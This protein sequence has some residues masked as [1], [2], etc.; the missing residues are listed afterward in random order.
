M[1]GTHK[2]I[3][4]SRLLQSLA[5]VCRAH[6]TAEK[7]LL[8]PSYQIGREILAAL[9]G[10]TG[11]WLNLRLETPFSLALDIAAPRMAAE[12]RT[13]VAS[14]LH[15]AILRRLYATLDKRFFPPDPTPGILAAIGQALEEIR[16]AE[17]PP[18]D[19]RILRTTDPAK[20]ADLEALLMRYEQ[21][22]D[23]A[24]AV[25]PP[26]VYR[27]ARDANASR[28]W[29][30][31]IPE[32]LRLP[33]MISDLLFDRRLGE[34]LVLEEDPG[35]GVDAPPGLAGHRSQRSDAPVSPLSFLFAPE[36][37]P[38]PPPAIEI[39]AAVGERNECREVLR[40]ILARSSRLDQV[41]IILADY[42][43]YAP[44]LDDLCG[45]L[46]S[47]PVTFAGGL[48]AA[49]S[50]PA[51]AVAA[52]ARWFREGFPELTLR[53]LL[54]SGDLR[55]PEGTTGRRAAHMLRAAQVG[56]GADR[57]A[58]CLNGY[59]AEILDE[60]HD[61]EDPTDAERLTLRLAGAKAARDWIL[62]LLGLVPQ[63]KAPLGD[64]LAAA[65]AFLEGYVAIRSPIDAAT[66]AQ[67]VVRLAAPPVEDSAPIAPA[68]AAEYILNA[69]E[70]IAVEASGS[71]PGHLHVSSIRNGGYTG[72]PVTY[73]LGLDDGRFPGTVFQDPILSDLERERLGVAMAV[74]R[75][76]VRSLEA[77]YAFGACLARLR[78]EIILSHAAFDLADGRRRFPSPALLQAHR[79]RTGDPRA[80]YEDLIR[81]V[82]P[83]IGFVGAS[84]P[85]DAGDWWLT[86]LQAEGRLQEARASVLA[87]APD[88]ARGAQADA[89]RSSAIATPHDGRLRPD[90]ARDPRINRA[91]VFSASRLEC[92]PSCPHKYFLKYVLRVEPPD[93]VT[94]E[95]G[96]WLDPMARGS[97]LHE[98]YRR[99]LDTFAKRNEHP[100]P[101]TH[102][103]E[104]WRIL[105][106]CIQEVRRR[107]PPPSEAVFQFEVE[108]LRR[109]VRVFLE[110]EATERATNRPSYFEVGFGMEGAE[111]IGTTTPV[112]IRLPGG[113][114][115]LRGKIDRIDR[116]SRAH[117]WEV[118]DYKTG[119]SKTYLRTQY[120]NG[121]TQLQHALY[122][123]V[124]ETLLRQSVD[125]KATV[126]GSGYLFPTERGGGA[127][128]RRD[129]A[130]AD[131]ALAVVAQICDGIRD[132]IFL[133]ADAWCDY[134]DYAPVCGSRGAA[135]W[136]A[137]EG[138]GDPAAA[139]MTEV[140]SHE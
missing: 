71:R 125:P 81:A 108:A 115:A 52:F 35:H 72:R 25:D 54:T 69:V 28:A 47:L 91:L 121:G 40:R 33:W 128:I 2:R 20:A 105:D 140:W 116:L 113:T 73:V 119:Q 39:F 104:A 15:E 74:G 11:G 89:A 82:G 32:S 13:L 122:A 14:A 23:R 4:A 90:P 48:P 49:R 24:K 7:R 31:L 58:L 137:L 96:T 126:V 21:E 45:E 53:R 10:L 5:A 120:T 68:D 77:R 22:L 44:L 109:S 79:L 60:L 138:A 92:Y 139:R 131:E 51:R 18:R 103:A 84:L 101:K 83:P 123:K 17:L 43:A 133:V 78:G 19:M 57:Y 56:L 41:E 50:G 110:G 99:C 67:G 124:A 36:G 46:G 85:L 38:A 127:A 70:R 107:I 100:D 129:P 130:R 55:A 30:L 88:L 27:M 66:V 102:L 118:W 95:P 9:A 111:G 6:P 134:C 29:R 86:A 59:C 135:R 64:F 65:R 37:A 76:A 97:L 80:T 16:L 75:S 136:K 106:D 98:F 1:A 34:V 3:K 93:E 112:E 63:G 61:A 117:A 42:A 87:A 94:L 132:G 8:V 26:V 12:G 62:D 114:I